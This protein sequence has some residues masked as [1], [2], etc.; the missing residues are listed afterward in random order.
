MTSGGRTARS[1]GWLSALFV[2]LA[3][4]P[5]PAQA[6]QSRPALWEIRDADTTVYLF[7]SIHALP[8]GVSWWSQP[9]GEAFSRSDDLMVETISPTQMSAEWSKSVASLA[10]ATNLPPLME[11]IPAEKRPALRA[12]LARNKLPEAAA[13]RMKSWFASMM[14]GGAIGGVTGATAA[15]GVEAVMIAKAKAAHKA[16]QQ[17]ETPAQQLEIFNQLPE[18]AQRDLLVQALDDPATMKVKFDRMIGGWAAGDLDAIWKATRQGTANSP[19][20]REAMI[21]NRDRML[22]QWLEGRMAKPGTSFAVLGAA[23]LAGPDSVVDRLKS[24]GLRVTRIQ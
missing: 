6:D 16:V 15:N 13:N 17:F 19:A 5:S 12:A 7:G 22:S 10:F 23:Y 9:L 11:R 24:R 3:H 20:L 8:P 1:L 18:A 2:A 14:I 4:L 21:T